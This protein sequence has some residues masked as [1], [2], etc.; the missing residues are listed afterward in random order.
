MEGRKCPKCGHVEG[1]YVYFC[2]VCGFK[3]EEIKG[4][5][6]K[7]LGSLPSVEKKSE[8]KIKEAN[9]ALSFPTDEKKIEKLDGE[10]YP[11]NVNVVQQ[12]NYDEEMVS[13]FDFGNGK[14]DDAENEVIDQTHTDRVLP[15]DKDS[16]GKNKVI[17]A[18]MGGVIAIL[19]I[20]VIALVNNSG[21]STSI[22]NDKQEYVASNSA[23]NESNDNNL[24]ATQSV[25]TDNSFEQTED[26]Y[27]DEIY[28]STETDTSWNDE[29]EYEPEYGQV[30][31]D[32]SI[33]SGID[34]YYSNAL[35]PEEYQFYNSGI[36]DF[37]F[38]YPTNLYCD[39][40]EYNQDDDMWNEY[41]HII[42]EIDFFG[43]RGSKLSFK[44]IQKEDGFSIDDATAY[45]H[46]IETGK[47]NEPT[48]IVFGTTSD[49]GKVIV[50][51]W[52]SNYEYPIYDLY[53]I[54]DDYYMQMEVIFPDYEDSYDKMCK[55]YVTECYYR[56]CGFS[57]SKAGTRSFQ[58]FAE[59]YE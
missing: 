45:V 38:W 41:G 52:D 29:T 7:S 43:S 11:E 49:H 3:T 53:K 59:N 6:S 24:E 10:I 47:L 42:K 18:V 31:S 13:S 15:K 51:G 23:E 58:E 50:T 20:A 25:E 44:L 21:G 9:E 56:L 14:E 33:Y 35:Q 57:D 8:E 46:A 12:G 19:V 4:E 26:S 48:D 55:A 2:T 54:E 1:K 17:I 36:A 32:F 28:D 34:E 5:S 22:S 16:N 40:K 30:N 39:V 27:S 37:S